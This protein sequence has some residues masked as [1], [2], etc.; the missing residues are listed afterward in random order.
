MSYEQAHWRQFN[1]F[2]RLLWIGFALVGS[3]FVLSA[4]GEILRSQHPTSSLVR[5]GPGEVVGLLAFGVVALAIG[6]SLMRVRPYRPDLGDAA[7]S[8]ASRNEMGADARSWWTGDVTR[9]HEDPTA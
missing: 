4:V 2:M 6:V 7:L 1:R 9:R 5:L 8:R 3:Y